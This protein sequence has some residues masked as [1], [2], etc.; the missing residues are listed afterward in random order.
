MI[1]QNRLGLIAGRNRYGDKVDLGIAVPVVD[2]QKKKMRRGFRQVQH[3]VQLQPGDVASLTQKPGP[4]A[5][6][7]RN[8]MLKFLQGLVGEDAFRS[9]Y[10]STGSSFGVPLTLNDSCVLSRGCRWNQ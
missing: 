4:G 8:D 1:A 9:L 6:H 10:L 7:S 3:P 5:Q 2:A